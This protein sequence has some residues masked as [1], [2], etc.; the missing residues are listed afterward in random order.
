MSESGLE[1]EIIV[2]INPYQTRVVSA[3][4]GHAERNIYRT[5]RARKAGRKHI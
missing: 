2:D 5:P 3:G 1:K 4:A